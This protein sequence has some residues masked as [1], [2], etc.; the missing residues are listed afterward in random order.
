M[1]EKEMKEIANII[2]L[3]LDENIDREIVKE[4]VSKLCDRFPLY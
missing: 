3:A 1:K 2:A 4:K